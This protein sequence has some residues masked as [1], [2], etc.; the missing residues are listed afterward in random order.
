[1]GRTCTIREDKGQ[2]DNRDEGPPKALVATEADYL[3][4]CQDGLER[5][6]G[7]SQAV[8]RPRT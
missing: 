1:M 5:Q 8:R 3:H 7:P 6:V 2:M 4:L